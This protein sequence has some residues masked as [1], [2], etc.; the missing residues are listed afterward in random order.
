MNT[1][2]LRFTKDGRTF[3]VIFL[4]LLSAT[5]ATLIMKKDK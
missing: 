2:F 1:T 3:N 5:F 4:L